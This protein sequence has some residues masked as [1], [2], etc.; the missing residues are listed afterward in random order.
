VVPKARSLTARRPWVGPGIG[1]VAGTALLVAGRWW[2]VAPFVVG[3]I[4]VLP[5]PGRRQVPRAA[6]FARSPLW[7]VVLA[8][9]IDYGGGW[10]Y[11]ALVDPARISGTPPLIRFEVDERPALE[12]GAPTTVPP[13]TNGTVAADDTRVAS[14]L[15][16]DK[17]WASD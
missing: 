7:V 16:R 12:L 15:G 9:L 13:F 2:G 14:L 8:L 10:T 17:P 5:G 11:D 1:V 4:G 6:R 3:A